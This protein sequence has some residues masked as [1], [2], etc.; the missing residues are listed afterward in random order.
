MTLNFTK[1]NGAGNDF[2]M[3]DNRDLSIS[4]TKEQI[5][6]LCDRHRGIGADGLLCVEPAT[7]DGDFKMR[8]YN[9][10]GGEAE[11]CGNGARCFGRFVNHL[12]GDKLTK[13]RFETLA[14]IISA[15]FEGSQVR[16]N[17]STPH[18]LKLSNHLEVAGAG[19]T[20]H[21][22]NTGVPH[23][24]VMVDDLETVPVREWGAALRYHEA[25]KPKGT[26]ANFSKVVAPGSIAIRTYERG[27]EDET[28]ACGTGM[29]A[30]ALIYHELTGEP[31]PISVLVKGGD[32]LKV[33]F[34]EPNKSE[35]T[36]VTLF[37]PADFV[38][39]GTVQ[40]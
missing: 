34:E 2:V 8:Y 26:N 38:F 11:M 7:A 25:F 9:A 28:L 32:T 12:H 10:D 20:V 21:S 4:L 29:V 5:E 1:M 17:M 27:V 37:G 36:N 14:G 30:C 15:E 24:V 33:G 39:Q 19:L 31:G 40:L 16:I 3:L 6:K 22:V 23:A 35:Y 13:I 18:N